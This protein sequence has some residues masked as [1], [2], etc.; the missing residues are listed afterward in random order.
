MPEEVRQK[1]FPQFTEFIKS[2]PNDIIPLLISGI[3]NAKIV[4]TVKVRDVEYNVLENSSVWNSFAITHML[5]GNFRKAKIIL[6]A[7]Q[8]A[9]TSDSATLTNYAAVLLNE[10]LATHKLHEENFKT[11]KECTYKA[12]VFDVPKRSE[13]YK[14]VLMPAFKNLALI[15][16]IESEHYL[17]KEEHFASFIIGWI[18]IEMSLMRIWSKFLEI[19]KYSQGKRQDMMNWD[20]QLIVE[21]LSMAKVIPPELKNDLDNLREIR[22]RLVH[23]TQLDPTIGEIKRCLNLGR[24]L[25]PILQ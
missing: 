18:S 12:F 9:G 22:N 2:K 3:K 19:L 15:R 1:L 7:M 14:G 6:E 21:I 23:G 10:M 25:I 13:L 16:N 24:Q 5:T 20:I 8:E 11:A 4:D 17:N